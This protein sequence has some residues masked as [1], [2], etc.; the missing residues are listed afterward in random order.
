MGKKKTKNIVVLGNNYVDALYQT[1]LLAKK[2]MI[3]AS[4]SCQDEKWE[5][6]GCEIV[7]SANKLIKLVGVKKNSLRHIA[8]AIDKLHKTTIEILDPNKVNYRES[9]SFLPNGIYDNGKLTLTINAK[10]KPFIQNLQK[11]FTKYHIENI[12]PLKS[13][14][15]IRIFELLKMNYFK[16]EYKI[17]VD[18]LKK[19]FGVE[20][21]Y[22]QYNNFKRNVLEKA[23]KELKQHCEIW[24][25]YEEIKNGQKVF[26]ILFLIFKQEKPFSVLEMI[27]AEK[28]TTKKDSSIVVEAIP[29]QESNEVQDDLIN[30][31]IKNGFVGAEK[32]LKEESRELVEEALKIIKG[33]GGIS[34]PGGLLR[35][36]VRFLKEQNSLKE[37]EKQKKAQEEQE[38]R[39]QEI[40]N[41][42]KKLEGKKRNR[43]E[44]VRL[45]NGMGQNDRY[46]FLKERGEFFESPAKEFKSSILK[47]ISTNYFKFAEEVQKHGNLKPDSIRKSLVLAELKE[48]LA[49]N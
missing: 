40:V 12:K 21:Q 39:E 13:G 41:E 33:Q 35:E 10:M 23:K 42:G 20:H 16:G 4:L 27:P 25:E 19:M 9:F 29:V 37:L 34:N 11:N 48:F 26:E 36:K 1:D 24:F 47:D 3:A 2:I 45:F 32:F 18:E 8:P 17:S 7:I 30:E 14:Y 28:D 49:K 15:S 22:Q 6:K 38:Q 31:L 44:C 46:L 43:E 5:P